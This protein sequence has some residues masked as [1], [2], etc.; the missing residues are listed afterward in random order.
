[1]CSE[2]SKVSIGLPVY[3]GE[4][5]LDQSLCS[6]LSQSYKNI[7]IIVSDNASTDTTSEICQKY[8]EQDDRIIYHRQNKN[9][10]P[11]WN[12]NYVLRQASGEYFMWCAHDDLWDKGW[13]STLVKNYKRKTCISFGHVVNI[14]NDNNILR[15]YSNFNFSGN[16]LS[17]LIK[18]YLA[19]DSNG[20]ANIIYGIYKTTELKN[21]GF[22]DYGFSEYGQDYQFIF[23]CLQ[24]GEI[25]TD[26]SVLLYKRIENVNNNRQSIFSKFTS[27]LLLNRARSYFMYPMIVSRPIYKAIFVGLFPIKYLVSFIYNFKRIMERRYVRK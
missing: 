12:F 13:I 26:P 7:E 3:N 11:L 10:G 25:S 15:T 20:K 2:T 4:K 1:M 24:N 9:M 16:K 8:S 17:R 6:L 5:Y 21:I 18:Y 23:D 22:K 27:L 14:D 19:E